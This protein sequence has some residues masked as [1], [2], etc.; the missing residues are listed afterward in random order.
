MAKKIRNYFLKVPLPFVENNKLYS[1]RIEK[2]KRKGTY[3]SVQGPSLFE[4]REDI[5]SR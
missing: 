2:R 5:T 1:G 4:K 3:L